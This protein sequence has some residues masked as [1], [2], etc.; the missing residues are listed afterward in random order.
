M[1]SIPI[2]SGWLVDAIA[3]GVPGNPWPAIHALGV[4][5]A[6]GAVFQ[7]SRQIVTFVLNR[8]SARAITTI[9]RD[10]FAKVQRFSA[11]W[12]ANSF[13]GA[14]VRKITRGMTAFDTFTDTLAFG[15]VPALRGRDRRDIRVRVSLAGAR[16][17]SSGVSI[18]LFLIVV[19]ASRSSGSAPRMSKRASGIRR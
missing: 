18:L 2:A 6:L 8:L 17:S 16:A 15:L 12:H 4:F 1:C 7:A 10:A 9:G 14:T 5:V 13:A 11:D 19:V 3:S